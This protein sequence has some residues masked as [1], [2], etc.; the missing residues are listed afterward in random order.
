MLRNLVVPELERNKGICSRVEGYIPRS[1]LIRGVVVVR[2]P[3]M[4]S[5]IKYDCYRNIPRSAPMGDSDPSN[6]S[7]LV[8][9]LYSWTLT[10]SGLADWALNV[11]DVVWLFKIS[12]ECNVLLLFTWNKPWQKSINHNKNKK[13]TRTKRALTV[14]LHILWNLYNNKTTNKKIK[15]CH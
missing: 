5:T 12:Q 4:L 13:I 8:I 11:W 1:A 9:S 14:I 7:E 2:V 3:W 6:P 15:R 10:T